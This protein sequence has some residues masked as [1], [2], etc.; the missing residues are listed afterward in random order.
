[1]KMPVAS[2]AG[3]FKSVFC[4]HGCLYLASSLG[5][6]RLTSK[7]SDVQMFKENVQQNPP[8]WCYVWGV[9]RPFG[10]SVTLERSRPNRIQALVLPRCLQATPM[11]PSVWSTYWIFCCSG[12]GGQ[13]F[14]Q[15]STPAL[16]HIALCLSMPCRRPKERLLADPRG[17]GRLSLIL[18]PSQTRVTGLSTKMRG[19]LR[20][21]DDKMAR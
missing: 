11:K 19:L 7:S 14:F 8:A 15:L 21:G 6:N 13:P 10:S 12:R 20:D 16:A 4:L 18:R 17:S 5:H 1:M 2:V 3:T 9:L